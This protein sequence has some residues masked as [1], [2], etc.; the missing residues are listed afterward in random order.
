[1]AAL[2]ALAIP[3]AGV[4][5]YLTLND[6][7][8]AYYLLGVAG[9][10]ACALLWLLWDGIMNLFTPR[11]GALRPNVT[12]RAMQPWAMAG[13]ASVLAAVAVS[14]AMERRWFAQDPLFPSWT[15]ETHPN[16]FEERRAA[17]AA[18]EL[19]GL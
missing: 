5:R 7:Q 15:S 1:V 16:A 18:K 9:M 13:T 17:A 12:T 4:L 19:E 2:A 8:S 6:E 10:A 14:T 11:S 3:A